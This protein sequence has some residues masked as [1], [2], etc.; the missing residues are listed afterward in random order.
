MKK[1]PPPFDP[2]P[3]TLAVKVIPKAKLEGIVGMRGERL[4]VK[5]ASPPEK[6]EANLRVIKLLSEWLSIPEKCITLVQGKTSPEKLFR[7]GKGVSS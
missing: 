3:E 4:V 2:I 1:T 7:I 5:V 6:G